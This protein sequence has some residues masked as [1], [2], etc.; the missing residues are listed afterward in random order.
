MK[1][2]LKYGLLIFTALI[3]IILL[4]ISLNKAIPKKNNLTCSIMV[5]CSDILTDVNLLKEE[6]R[7]LLP[8]D[9]VIYEFSGAA[10]SDGETAFDVLERELKKEKIHID[11]SI[12]PVYNTVYIKGIGNI[13]ERDCGE[14]SGWTYFVNN[15][16]PS[17]GASDYKLKDGDNI[18]FTYKI[19]AY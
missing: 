6:K 18:V 13:Y 19:K 10:F 4:L 14:R 11:F 7:L 3:V 17:V 1:K 9:G 8:D 12:T 5:D 16:S 2:Y 15:E